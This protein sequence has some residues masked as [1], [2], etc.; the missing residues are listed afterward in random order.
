M[1]GILEVYS[2][3][4]VPTDWA[5]GKCSCFTRDQGEGMAG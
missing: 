5:R 3:T 4:L 2:T 1:K